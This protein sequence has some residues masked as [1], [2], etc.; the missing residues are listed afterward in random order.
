MHVH[1]SELERL[2]VASGGTARLISARTT[3]T[4][5]VVGDPG[6]PRGSASLAFNIGSPGAADLIDAT[7]AVTEVRVET[8]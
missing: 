6:L 8:T 3:V 1:P 7:A 4:L 5:P 2:G